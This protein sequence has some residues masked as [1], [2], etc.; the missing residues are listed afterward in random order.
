MHVEA[1]TGSGWPHGHDSEHGEAEARAQGC[2]NKRQWEEAGARQDWSRRKHGDWTWREATGHRPSVETGSGQVATDWRRGW[3]PGEVYTG[4]SSRAP[5]EVEEEAASSWRDA[6]Q[7]SSHRPSVLHQHDTRFTKEKARR[8]IRCDD[9]QAWCEGNNVGAFVHDADHIPY[10]ARQG[11]W[12]EAAYKQGRWD[13]TW[14]CLECHRKGRESE[15]D[16]MLRLGMT[17]RMQR[18]ARYVPR[19]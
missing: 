6:E 13:A 4:G 5:M 19:R 9:C 2:S 17:Y 15:G 10:A 12:R 11:A 14:Y 18:K 8:R 3:M 7:E 1:D 16:V